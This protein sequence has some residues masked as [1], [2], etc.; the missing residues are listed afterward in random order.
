M[1][2]LLA[3]E[4]PGIQQRRSVMRQR[5]CQEKAKQIFRNMKEGGMLV[6]VAKGYVIKDMEAE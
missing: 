3:E 6:K 4:T 5:Q 2:K 1:V